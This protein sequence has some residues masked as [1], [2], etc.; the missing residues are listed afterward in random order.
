MASEPVTVNYQEDKIAFSD[1]QMIDSYKKTSQ[2][3]ILT[4]NGYDLGAYVLLTFILKT[5]R[6][7]YFTA[8]SII[9]KRF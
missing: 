3:N 6:S 8:N 1:M 7:S 4:K 2:E 5:K 9:P